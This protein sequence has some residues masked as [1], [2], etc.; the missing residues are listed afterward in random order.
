[1]P[2]LDDFKEGRFVYPKDDST[3]VEIAKQIE[4][5]AERLNQPI[6]KSFSLAVIL[7][8]RVENFE[9]SK[10]VKNLPKIKTMIIKTNHYQVYLDQLEPLYNYGVMPKNWVRFPRKF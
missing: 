3:A 5:L 1:M 4:Y 7:M 2:V 6:S 8:N 9:P 10:L